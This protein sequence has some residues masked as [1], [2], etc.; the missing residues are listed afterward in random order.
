MKI[1]F[2]VVIMLL[3]NYYYLCGEQT[4]L[5]A[6]SCSSKPFAFCIKEQHIKI[7][8]TDRR[9]ITKYCVCDLQKR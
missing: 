9:M 5:F 7:V 2:S 8:E 1:F 6:T 4:M 3:G